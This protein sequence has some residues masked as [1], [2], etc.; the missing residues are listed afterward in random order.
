LW[1]GVWLS[2]V[3]YYDQ[4][5]EYHHV[6]GPN[7]PE[8]RITDLTVG[9][10]DRVWVAIRDGGASVFD[11][12]SW[13]HYSQDD[14]GLTDDSVER[15]LVDSSGRIWLIAGYEVSVLVGETWNPFDLAPFSQEGGFGIY[16]LAESPDGTTTIVGTHPDGIIVYRTTH[17][18]RP[19]DWTQEYLIP[20]IVTKGQVASPRF[21]LSESKGWVTPYPTALLPVDDSVWLGTTYGLFRLHDDDRLET[22]PWPNPVTPPAAP[23]WSVHSGWGPTTEFVQVYEFHPDYVRITSVGTISI[24]EDYPSHYPDPLCG[25]Q[26]GPDLY[27]PHDVTEL[28]ISENITICEG[29]SLSSWFRPIDPVPAGGE[30]TYWMSEVVHRLPHLHTPHPIEPGQE[31]HFGLRAPQPQND[32]RWMRLLAVPVSADITKVHGTPPTAEITVGDWRLFV[33]DVSIS[34]RP[35]I[36][37]V[38]HDDALA[39]SLETYLEAA[40]WQ[41]TASAEE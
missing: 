10:D 18:E 25:S 23:S 7:S 31:F 12:E 26:S 13:T 36:N 30:F 20:P 29:I 40:G 8:S 21:R 1:I 15:I 16:D 33:Y 17:L 27:N 4:D 38:L 19:S 28:V 39:P 35:H 22:I 14:S 5:M 11:G 6:S 41:V 37:F 34:H 2:G 3:G 9:P 32:E 24:T